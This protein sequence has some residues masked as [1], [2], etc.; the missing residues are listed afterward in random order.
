MVT[1]MVIMRCGCRN[2]TENDQHAAALQ[3][4]WNDIIAINLK[5]A[6][7]CKNKH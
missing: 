7:G 6:S 3:R 2:H 5:R 1:E 4:V